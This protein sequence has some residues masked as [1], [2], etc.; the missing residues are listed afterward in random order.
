MPGI[1]RGT[2]P[3]IGKRIH[4]HLPHPRRPGRQHLM[5]SGR[6]FPP[7]WNLTGELEEPVVPDQPLKR[8]SLNAWWHPNLIRPQLRREYPLNLSISLSGG[9]ENNH[10]SPSNGE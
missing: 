9:K 1:S 3:C 2:S 10:D 7:C 4:G 5:R 6:F 8:M